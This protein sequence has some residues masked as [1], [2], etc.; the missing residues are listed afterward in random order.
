[1][2]SVYDK[3][4]KTCKKYLLVAEYYSLSPVSVPYRGHQNKLFKRDFAGEIMKK[5]PTMKLID[6]GFIYRKD[7]KFPL[8]DI[9]WFLMEKK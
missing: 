5:H 2:N 8:D 1:M 9:T 6:Y 4:V 7:P 3:L